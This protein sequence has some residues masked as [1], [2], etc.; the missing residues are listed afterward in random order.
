MDGAKQ[1]FIM[2]KQALGGDEAARAALEALS[3]ANSKV[4]RSKAALSPVDAA[5]ALKLIADGSRL[6]RCR[7]L[8][9]VAL[10]GDVD[11]VALS[12]LLLRSHIRERALLATALR[13]VERTVPIIAAF[14][15]FHH[16]GDKEGALSLLAALPYEVAEAAVE[17]GLLRGVTNTAHA[18]YLWCSLARAHPGLVIKTLASRA[19]EVPPRAAALAAHRLPVNML[20]C[21][22]SLP[23]P[24]LR[25]VALAASVPAAPVL[26]QQQADALLQAVLPVLAK[27][28]PVGLAGLL[29]ARQIKAPDFLGGRYNCGRNL[30]GQQ[31]AIRSLVLGQ[32]GAALLSLGWLEPE[33]CLRRATSLKQREAMWA[34]ISSAQPQ[35]TQEPVR[36]PLLFL[37]PS[38]ARE[39]AVEAAL[40]SSSSATASTSNPRDRANYA[41]FTGNP[42]LAKEATSAAMQDADA[43]VRC[44][45]VARRFAGAVRY[46]SADAIEEA[47]G[48]V[49]GRAREQEPARRQLLSEIQTVFQDKNAKGARRN[50]TS[51]GH[52]DQLVAAMASLTA[53]TGTTDYSRRVVGNILACFID[54]P[55]GFEAVQGWLAPLAPSGSVTMAALLVGNGQS[56]DHLMQ[57]V[58]TAE[59]VFG[60]IPSRCSGE[61]LVSSPT[62]ASVTSAVTRLVAGCCSD[63][64]ASAHLLPLLLARNCPGLCFSSADMVAGLGKLVTDGISSASGSS[65]TPQA[66]NGSAGDAA[67]PAAQHAH[68]AFGLLQAYTRLSASFLPQLLDSSSSPSAA[69]ASAAR[70]RTWQF[71]PTLAHA[72]VPHLLT[73]ELVGATMALPA[74]LKPLPAS[75]IRGA[76]R[77]GRSVSYHGGGAGGGVP[78]L[79]WLPR[80][81]KPKMSRTLPLAN[82]PAASQVLVADAG[83]AYV[84]AQLALM[85]QPSSSP[86]A[87]APAAAAPMNNFNLRMVTQA[88][89]LIASC[90]FASDDAVATVLAAAEPPPPEPDTASAASSISSA[91]GQEKKE[92]EEGEAAPKGRRGRGSNVDAAEVAAQALRAAAIGVAAVLDGGEGLPVMLRGLNHAS[93]AEAAAKLLP[94]ATAGASA[95]TVA[96]AVST[97]ASLLQPGAPCGVGVQKAAVGAL[98]ALG[99]LPAAR[100]ALLAA[101]RPRPADVRPL[102]RDVLTTLQRAQWEVIILEPAGATTTTSAA[103]AAEAEEVW[104]QLGEAAA[105][106]ASKPAT[107]VR[108]WALRMS[109]SLL[110]LPPVPRPHLAVSAAPSSASPTEPSAMAQYAKH[111]LLPLLGSQAHPLRN[112]AMARI[113]SGVADGGSTAAAAKWH[114]SDDFV[115][116]GGQICALLQAVAT[117]RP[118]GLPGDV[119]RGRQ[120]RHN[121][122]TALVKGYTSGQRVDGEVNGRGAQAVAAVA[123]TLASSSLATAGAGI[124]DASEALVAAAAAHAGDLCTLRHLVEQL[125]QGL[126]SGR[127]AAVT[128]SGG[129]REDG[130][131]VAA[132]ALM[133]VLQRYP[134]ASSLLMRLT[135]ASASS[136]SEL[137]QRLTSFAPSF[138]ARGMLQSALDALKCCPFSRDVAAL[139]ALE[140]ELSAAAHLDAPCRGQLL[141]LALECLVLVAAADSENDK[142]GR[143]HVHVSGPNWTPQRLARLVQCYCRDGDAGVAQAA[144]WAL[145]DWTPPE[146]PAHVQATPEASS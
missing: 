111:V 74:D 139:E 79:G 130:P 22:V 93:T 115:G 18:T 99:K 78:G 134:V 55:A 90:P 122:V 83:A 7:A 101:G 128:G 33:T 26:D 92:G 125:L 19:A 39:S 112:A 117:Q 123:D 57:V 89:R 51:S 34:V 80:T 3:Q 131:A 67:P 1:L 13:R 23:L 10:R 16:D 84:R 95:E 43:S 46:G 60:G 118:V 56:V 50:V 24:P 75:Y 53:G 138:W 6:V 133:A 58:R 28:C 126:T 110:G 124:D 143:N 41:S 25:Q 30:W 86:P 121:A 77:R 73:P 20:S 104:R 106:A 64:D 72:R 35:L 32:H 14:E 44:V 71:L 144:E 107:E 142:K 38:Q 76:G 40:K 63:Y 37:L 82:W 87:A 69:A 97:L 81:G 91:S 9:S 36:L 145:G 109:E 105:A 98:R 29:T 49:A 113:T 127:A 103:A 45:A 85:P 137:S 96:G 114:P 4:D 141:R 17:G 120:E 146:A 11:D 102:H 65:Q 94:V 88:L 12:N 42:V 70:L 48:L 62:R 31:R 66:Q 119:L 68:E 27:R 52:I 15:R 116:A 54:S 61:P 59:S 2:R 108:E 136:P 47:L 100:A 135:F 129:Q 5:A 8:K 140:S 132:R 21:L